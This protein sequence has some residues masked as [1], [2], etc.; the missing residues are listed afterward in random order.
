MVIHDTGNEPGLET[1]TG[2]EAVKRHG[3][4]LQ[5]QGKFKQAS[6]GTPGGG[7]WLGGQLE[8]PFQFGW[9]TEKVVQAALKFANAKCEGR[10]YCSLGSKT[11]RPHMAFPFSQI[12]TVV[13]TA[14]GSKPPPLGSPALNEIPWQ[15]ADEQICVD[16]EH[17]YTVWYNTQWV[18]LCSWELLGVPAIS[19]LPL[20]RILGEVSKARVFLY[21]LGV[22][23]THANWQSAPIW[24]FEFSLGGPDDQWFEDSNTTSSR[25]HSEVS[26]P[27]DLSGSGDVEE[28]LDESDH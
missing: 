23:E 26:D 10:L 4:A 14:P 8:L 19:P 25:T 17:T 7:L 18:D 28:H 27:S 11:E 21:D 6:T 15:G 5:V 24:E 9:V 16:T 20:E 12:F 22:T 13:K 1:E 3:V 2:T